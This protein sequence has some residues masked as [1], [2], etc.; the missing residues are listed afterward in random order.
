ML[1]SRGVFYMSHN[2]FE[3]LLQ[4]QPCF[5]AAAN[6]SEGFYN[7]FEWLSNPQT[8][9][10]YII[11]GGPGTGKSSLMRELALTMNEQG[12]ETELLFCSS[13]PDSLDGVRFPTLQT[14]IIDGTA[15]HAV[16][17]NYLGVY[18]RLVNLADGLCYDGIKAQKDIL[19][20]L[21]QQN[22]HLHLRVSRYLEAAGRLADDSFAADCELVDATKA[23]NFAARLAESYLGFHSQKGEQTRRFLSGMT[24]KGTMLLEQTLSCYTQR[25][26]IVEDEYG[27]ASS[28][29]MS[30]IRQ[31][32][33]ERGHKV[34]VCPCA[35]NP[36]RKIDHL[37]IPTADIAFCTA[38]THLPITT[39]PIRR[40]HAR[41]FRDLSAFDRIKHRL[42][43]NTRAQEELLDSACVLLS[44]A[45]A[46]HDQIEEIYRG[47]MDFARWEQ[48]KDE[49]AAQLHQRKNQQE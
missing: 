42:R 23:E 16:E 35:L 3:N 19:M 40:I 36:S 28:V 10:L 31:I 43:F 46:V 37:I 45:K 25:L 33:L 24:P 49:V 38:N 39:E 21:F 41:R 5:F 17:P 47:Q 44:K 4:T 32:A 26:V 9:R 7:G 20:P 22:K 13:D 1:F 14:V 48:I 6:S 18:E 29:V 34:I 12:C 11:K 30:V 15:P 2:N 8:D 27:G